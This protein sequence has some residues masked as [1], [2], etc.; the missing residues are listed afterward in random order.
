MEHSLTADLHRHIRGEVRDDAISK[1][2]YSV[3]ASI[4][5]ITPQVIVIPLD[6]EDVK[7]AVAIAREHHTAIIPRGAATGIAGGCI[8]DGLVIDVSKYLNQIKTINYEEGYAICEPGVIQNQLNNAL[9]VR[10][11]RLGPDTSTGNRATLSGM[12]ANNAA[13]ARS[14]RYGKMGDHTQ[15]V[16]L[17]LYGGELLR[18]GDINSDALTQKL[19]LNTQEGKIYREIER[20]KDVYAEEIQQHF[21]KIPRRVSGYNLNELLTPD[22]LNL[23]K[24]I[25]GSE[26]SLGLITEMRVKIT[27]RPKECG[28]CLI[29]SHSLHEALS[30]V[31]TILLWN[32]LSL[33]MIDNKI[34]TAG[35][36]VP[37]TSK[38]TGWIEGNPQ[39]ILIV[40]FEAETQQALH[41]T[42]RLFEEAMRD[43][44]HGYHVKALLTSQEMADVWAVRESGVG[45]LLSKRS[46]NRA[47]AFLEDI[48]VSPLVLAPFME[49]FLVL[50]ASY[51]KDA[52]VYGHA[53]SGCMHIRPYVDLRDPNELITMRALMEA[54]SSLLLKYQG[55]LSGEHGDGLVRSWLN[56]KMFG[57]RL[58]QAFIEIKKA[59]D[60]DF[61]MNPGKIVANQNLEENLRLNPKTEVQ[62]IDTVYDFSKE[63]G[64]SLAVDMCNGNGMCRKREG[65]MCPSFQAY[66]DEFHSTRA[67]AQSLRAIVNG[68]LPLDTFTS[69]ELHHVLEYCLECKGCKTQCP[70]QVDMAKMKA[71]FLH[72][73]QN[74]WGASLRSRL[75]AH[76]STINRLSSPAYSL[77]NA[78]NQSK[79]GKRLLNYLEITP[80]RSL[81][82]LSS[83]RFSYQLQRRPQSPTVIL[84]LDTYTEFNHPEIGYAVLKVLDR[85]GES[86]L[87]PPWTCCGRPLISK[88]FLNKAKK[89]ATKV[90]ETFL[91]YAKQGL[92]IVGLEPSCI[93]TILDDYPDLLRG[94]DA[95]TLATACMSLETFLLQR[96]LP[97]LESSI[98]QKVYFHTH[99]HQKALIGSQ[100]TLAVLENLPNLLV[101]EITAGCCG[102][103]GSFGYEKEHYEMSMQ[104]GENHLFPAVRNAPPEAY[105][106][107]NGMS[108][109]SQI[110]HGT[111]R[112]ALHFVQFLASYF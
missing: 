21:P 47:I 81:P 70:S 78:F 12:L 36:S 63:G 77:F 60:P 109:R 104:I 71:E 39:A 26:G 57:K 59:F 44:H 105:I 7:T 23:S 3:D 15:E 72:H 80:E 41:H 56:E 65:L 37:M 53:G 91:P 24:L 20:I 5:E 106:L 33:E 96:G 45:L 93:F 74:K 82:S 32:P 52:G 25:A 73:Y 102:L 4:Y 11:Y 99:C 31:A 79:I 87:I 19:L 112:R 27:Q 110:Y 8:G 94:P 69:R 10:N 49:E 62:T 42:L 103:A 100:A 6:I 35:R 13:G 111:Q 108:C 43:N 38:R 86:V 97:N 67:R 16:E 68:R 89:Q 51:H 28:I 48:S 14:L 66:G 18:F 58:Y 107:A 64:F 54:A 61:R 40:E 98:E 92:P 34:I 30:L 76:I 50:L 95:K 101:S 83:Q 1:A 75:F 88:G 85:M 2:V 84:F 22:S 29:H 46:Y 90:V 55:S 9:A 17:L